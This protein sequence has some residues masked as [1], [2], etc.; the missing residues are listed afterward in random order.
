MPDSTRPGPSGFDRT[1]AVIAGIVA[2][3]SYIVYAMT[4]QRSIP[5]WDCGEF[6]ACSAILGIPHPPGTPLFV[7]MGRLISIVPFVEDISYRINYL[8]VIS[9]A[10]TAMFAY[11]VTVR[12]VRYF[13]NDSADRLSRIIAYLGGFTGSLFVAFSRTNW[14]NSVESEVYGLGL[15]ISLAIVWLTLRYFEQKGSAQASRYLV[16]VFYLALL[17]VGVHMVVFLVLPACAVYF[18]LNRNAERRDWLVLCGFL[19][20]ELL[21]ILL[22]ALSGGNSTAFYIISALLAGVMLMFIYNKIS[23]ALLIGVASVA[24]VMTSFSNY[25]LLTPIMLGVLIVLAFFSVRYRLNMHWRTAIAIVVIGVIGMSVHLFIPIRSTLNPRIDQNNT[26][27]GWQQ[28]VDF[29]DRKQYGQ[30]SMVDRMFNRRGKLENQFGRHAHMGFWSYF[31][32]QYSPSGWGFVPFFI[33]GLIGII[34]AIRK[35]IEIGLPFLT[36]LLVCSVGLILYM[37]FA[38]G[39]QY[40]FD[41]GDAYMEVRNRDYFFTPAF[42]FF[43]I[44]MGLGISAIVQYLRDMAPE[45]MKK[46]AVYASLVL[47]LLPGISLAH[48]YHTNDRSQ[49]YIPYVYG[50]NLL[51]TCAP[52][53]IFFTAGDNDTFPLWCLQE[54]YNYRRDV[55]IVNLSLLQTDWYVEQM[56]D[57]FDIP[58][59]LTDSQIVWYPYEIQPGVWGSRPHERFYDRPR[60]RQTYMQ[61]NVFNGRVVR[62]QDMVMEDIILENRWQH[63]V[64]YSTPPYAESPL[65]LRDRATTVG[66]GYR[67]D[68]EPP[69]PLVD[70]ER[71]YELFMREYRFDGLSDSKVYRD[72]NATGVFVSHGV[73]ALRVYNELVARKD[74]VR[75]DSLAEKIISVY[76]EYWQMYM[77]YGTNLDQRGDSAKTTQLYQQLS[78]TLTSFVASNPENLFYLMDLGLI[79]AE[80]GQRL[81]NPEQS[82]EGVALA[83]EAFEGDPNSSFA[84][85]KL[86]TLLLSRQRYSDAQ[87]AAQM[88][89]EYRVNLSDG[90]VRQLLGISGDVP[91][92]PDM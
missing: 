4:V 62:V 40:N 3:I 31:E 61:A 36:I 50:K 26:S 73:G 74:T 87:R 46:T 1:N 43:G 64:F 79:K 11:L 27:R 44:A 88:H 82:A 78:D 8:S 71:G 80:L 41:T 12:I 57:R 68:R 92:V 89:A 21:L 70:V 65:K 14:G 5:F 33:L 81:G 86:T 52:N 63:P 48:S 32:E 75:A 35:R 84:F 67:L 15:A 85:H 18:I 72:E 38:D 53:S 13:A 39:T 69:D 6:I 83:W 91:Q 42:V 24:S 29:L 51:D 28:F 19:I 45:S 66:I 20:A 10:F 23:W 7:L 59:T 76:P 58:M 22:I 9:S 2:L 49:N 55:R 77:M 54:A 17:G 30:V 34:V 47:A 60:K 25:I 16:M 56:K 37:N 90:L